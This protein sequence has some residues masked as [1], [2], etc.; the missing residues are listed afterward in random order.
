MIAQITLK[1]KYILLVRKFLLAIIRM[2]TGRHKTS[3]IV[4]MIMNQWVLGS[5]RDESW[6]CE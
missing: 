5:I 4:K 1:I 6:H 3:E 2:K